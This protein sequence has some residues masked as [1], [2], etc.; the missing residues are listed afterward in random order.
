MS[1][2]AEALSMATEDRLHSAVWAFHA[3]G[4]RRDGM[5][6]RLRRGELDAD[7]QDRSLSAAE[8]VVEARV[9]LYKMLIDEGWSPPNWVAH[10]IE[11][12]DTV[13]NQPSCE[14]LPER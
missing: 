1:R 3:A 5:E 8:A 9:A 13:L 7:L 11:Y 4:Q 10:D 2:P 12:D 6:L 14:V